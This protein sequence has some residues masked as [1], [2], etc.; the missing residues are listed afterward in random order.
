MSTKKRESTAFADILAMPTVPDN[1]A[2]VVAQ[3]SIGQV[4]PAA[5]RGRPRTRLEK[6]QTTTIRLSEDNH[7]KV[8]QLALRD[9]MPMNSLILAAVSEYCQ[10][11]GVLLDNELMN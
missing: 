9:R 8:R 2:P 7:Q 1:P 11:R 3:E 5:K 4:S 6:P 10:R